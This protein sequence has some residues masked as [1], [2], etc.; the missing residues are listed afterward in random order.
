VVLEAARSG[1]N[2]GFTYATREDAAAQVADA[3]REAGDGVRVACWPLDVRDADAVDAVVDAALSEFGSV[4]AVV[5]NAGVNLNGLAYA[6]SD[7]DWRTVIDTN[8]TGSFHVCRAFLPELVANRGGR[9]LMMSSI[10]AQG[11]SGQAAYAASKAGIQ[12]LAQTLAKEYGPKGVTTNVVVPGYFDTDMTRGDGMADTLRDFA[13][14]YCPLRR[15]G[16]LDELAKTV[17]F[18]AGDGA[19][20]INGAVIPVTGGLGWAP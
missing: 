16:E 15:L 19:G 20:F 1:W 5:C 13:V 14:T 4:Q 11:A 17:L 3:A 12:G 8:L 10:T 6:V 18:L 9:I 2:V 7:E